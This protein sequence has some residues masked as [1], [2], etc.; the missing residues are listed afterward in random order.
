MQVFPQVTAFGF[1]LRHVPEQGRKSHGFA[2]VGCDG[3]LFDFVNQFDNV[4]CFAVCFIQLTHLFGGVNVNV[5]HIVND[6]PFGFLRQRGKKV[7][8]SADY[9]R[10]NVKQETA[11]VCFQGFKV[12]FKQAFTV[13][14]PVHCPGKIPLCVCRG[15]HKV[16]ITKHDLFA[17]RHF[18]ERLVKTLLQCERFKVRNGHIDSK[19]FQG[20]G[21]A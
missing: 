15:L 18:A 9:R 1:N 21:F 19:L 6:C 14:K 5:I 16:L 4:T 10:D 7:I 12:G 20:F 17:L 11:K 2:F 13:R 3:L 8:D